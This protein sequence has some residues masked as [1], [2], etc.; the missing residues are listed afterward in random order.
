MGW[1][2]DQGHYKSDELHDL[3]SVSI[4]KWKP[5]LFFMQPH[6][7]FRKRELLFTQ[8][9]VSSFFVLEPHLSL[10]GENML[11]IVIYLKH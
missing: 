8:F 4:S 10:E 2:L 1:K 3:L 7:P 9:A 11:R 6:L 5:I